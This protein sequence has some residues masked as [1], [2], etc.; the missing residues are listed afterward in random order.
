[1]TPVRFSPS[2]LKEG[3]WYEYLVRLAL[4]GG[5]TVFTGLVSS[6]YGAAVGG[7]FLALPAIFCASAT[8]VESHERRTKEKAGLSGRRRGQEAAALDAAGAAWGSIGLVAFA[9]VFHLTVPAG[10]AGAFIAALSAWAVISVSAWWL[11]RKLRIVSHH[12]R[13]SGHWPPSAKNPRLFA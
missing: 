8:L 2:S 10:I 9:A 12:A 13:R 6:R 5:A 3:R 11:R 1:M 7:L 4:G